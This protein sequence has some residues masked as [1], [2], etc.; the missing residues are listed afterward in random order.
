MMEFLMFRYSKFSPRDL[1]HELTCQNP[2]IGKDPVSRPHLFV[3]DRGPFPTDVFLTHV[4]VLASAAVCARPTTLLVQ[5]IVHYIGFEILS[6]P[7]ATRITRTHMFRRHKY[8]RGFTTAWP[9]R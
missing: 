5:S 1:F 8:L 6:S 2:L 9:R 3:S 7:R 4:T